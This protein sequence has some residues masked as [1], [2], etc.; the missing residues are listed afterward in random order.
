M[1]R[2]ISIKFRSIPSKNGVFM[3]K[4]VG[5]FHRGTGFVC[6]DSFFNYESSD[7]VKISILMSQ[8]MGN[9]MP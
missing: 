2:K 8:N 4:Y 6:F 3:S 9:V 1:R 5:D 7:F